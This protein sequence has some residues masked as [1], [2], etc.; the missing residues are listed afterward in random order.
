MPVWLECILGAGYREFV[1]E[2]AEFDRRMIEAER[3][4]L[5]LDFRLSRAEDRI[6]RLSGEECPDDGNSHPA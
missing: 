3:K 1:R 5:A 2:N 6:K 4:L